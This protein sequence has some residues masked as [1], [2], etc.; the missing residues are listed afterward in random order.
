MVRSYEALYIVHPELSDEQ[1]TA[2]MEK[3]KGVVESQGGEVESV[4]R[5][6]KRRLA[7]EVKGQ[8]EGIYVLM[9]YKSDAK[10]SSELD[11]LQRIGDD[12]LRHII[13]RLD[14]H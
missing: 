3:Y 5:W 7:Y 10:A 4:N 12:V 2:I 9:N 8:R 6:E 1:V 13:V 14:E 11:R